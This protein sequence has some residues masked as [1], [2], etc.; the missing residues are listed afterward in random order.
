[1][2]YRSNLTAPDLQPHFKHVTCRTMPQS[3]GHDVLSDW[4]DKA[5]DDPVF[6]IF[7]RCGFM[8][9][10]EAAILYNVAKIAGGNWCDIGCHTGWT[11]LHINAG[12]EDQVDCV[13]Y[14]LE[15]PE[16][17][18]RLVTNTQFPPHWR[19]PHKS[20]QFFKNFDKSNGSR[21]M[22]WTGFCIDG[23]HDSPQPQQDGHNAA[24]YLYETGVIIFHDFIG[25]PVQEAV[26][27]LMS[28]GFRTKVY[29][30]PHMVA[31]CWRGDFVPPHHVRDPA[32]TWGS[33]EAMMAE[34][35]FEKCTC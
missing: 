8:T 25:R 14:M 12:T 23:D 32:I 21:G 2:I 6:G 24:R 16:F 17:S 27:Y 34:F 11:S 26:E 22:R 30:T 15:L 10:D 9:H 7:K 5:D 1:M 19:W 29:W 33:V 31:C 28:I 18:D 35:P 3:M 20:H 13:D 4:A